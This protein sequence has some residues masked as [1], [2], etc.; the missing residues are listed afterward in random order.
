MRY[1]RSALKV[2]FS[3]DH[4]VKMEDGKVVIDGRDVESF[5]NMIDYINNG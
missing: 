2:M 5:K 1:E 3:G 4:E